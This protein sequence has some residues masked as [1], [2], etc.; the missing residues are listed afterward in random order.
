MNRVTRGAFHVF[1]Y[2]LPVS[3]LLIGRYRRDRS[4]SSPQWGISMTVLLPKWRLC[5]DLAGQVTHRAH[6]EVLG[7]AK[8][9]SARSVA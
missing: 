2:Y 6:A 8:R 7:S 5:Y 3:R 1:S 9:M 4:M